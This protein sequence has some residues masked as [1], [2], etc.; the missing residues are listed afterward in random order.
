MAVLKGTSG[1]VVRKVTWSLGTVLFV[2]VFNFFLFRM[3]PGDPISLYTKG[4]NMPAEQLV[5]LRAQL[6][7]PLPEQF[8]TYLRNPFASTI[9]STRFNR[10]VWD[11]IGERVWPTI[12]LVGTAVLI[13]SVLGVWLG[14]R[15]GW[16][17]GSAFDSVTTG[18]TNTLYAAPEF[19]V[20]MMLIIAVPFLP[21]G[22]MS[23]PGE[24]GVLDVAKH[25]ILP[26]ISL[27]VVY[28]AEYTS[29]MRA[30]L[31]DEL[32]QDYLTLARAKGLRED[33][34]RR[35]HAVPN[36]LLPTMTLIFLNFGFVIGGAITVEAVYSWPG[37][38]LLSYDALR[39]PD[40]PLLQAV[41]L[42]FSIGVIVFTLIA[43]LLYA[44]IDP[45]VSAA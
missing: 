40:V 6:N 12:L 10:P 11:M 8:L 16:R 29:I 23:N 45:R 13:A 2:L 9:N 26:V 15:A 1:Y 39:G 5:K 20:G 3:L 38:G 36:A 25:M 28:L 17:R 33:L 7:R 35:R 31:V 34:V 42:L 41:F 27:S 22:G 37:L 21:S 44:V 4:R 24:G 32:R 43:D 19:W 18:I 14:I 30:S